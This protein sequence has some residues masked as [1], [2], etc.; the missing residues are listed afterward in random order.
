MKELTKATIVFSAI[1][2][3]IIKGEL[4]NRDRLPAVRT[5]AKEFNVSNFTILKAFELLERE[6]LIARAEK[7]GVFIKAKNKN[8]TMAHKIESVKTRAQEIAD[9]IISESIHGTLKVGDYLTMK[10]VLVFKYK[11]S[12]E[13]I[14]KVIEFLI[15]GKYIHKDGYRYRIG[16]P[17]VSVLRPAKNHVYILA[18]REPGSWKF[19][20]AHDRNF[21]EPFELELQ[22]HGVASFEY[23]NLWNEPGLM[24]RVKEATTAGFLMDF[25]NLI[26]TRNQG[27]NLQAHFYTIAE[28]VSKKHLPLIV[29]SYNQVLRYI[30]DFLFKPIPNLFFIGYDDSLAGERIGTYLASMGHKKIAY[31][32]FGNVPW[33]LERFKGVES[34]VTRLHADRSNVYYFH[35][36]PADASWGADISTYEH[37]TREKK[38]RFLEG[39]SELFDGYQFQHADPLEEVYPYLADRIYKD[40]R[41]KRMAPL[42][43]KALKIKE[44]TAWVGTGPFETIAAVEFL[45][46]H[47]VDIPN[48]ISLAGFVDY[49]GTMEYGITTFNFMEGKAAYLAAHCMLGDIPVKKNRK[50]YVEYEGQI[51]VRKSVK[52]I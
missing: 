15:D 22:K 9:T 16:Q 41:K 11:T 21:F 6:H 27:E 8:E 25:E 18:H 35:D 49:E 4:R 34:A 42:F 14:N 24:N 50:G 29:D 28:S 46:E 52:A 1:K 13:T 23:L 10:K 30:P 33:N 19:H 44:I 17:T 12:T 20:D 38:N 43:E 40:I 7:S 2:N 45:M 5:L 32:N 47:G 3:K 37:T 51:M 39:Y 36:N 31:F 48:E 26:A